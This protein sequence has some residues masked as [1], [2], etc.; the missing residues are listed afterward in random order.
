MECYL[1]CYLV[2]CREGEGR[3][4]KEEVVEGVCMKE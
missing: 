3:G 2:Q 4:E 1:L